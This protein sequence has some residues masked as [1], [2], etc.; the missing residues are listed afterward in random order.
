[1]NEVRKLKREDLIMKRRGLNFIN[2]NVADKLD[3]EQIATLENEVDNVA[4]KIVG[5]L[6]LSAGCDA[7]SLRLEMVKHCIEYQQSLI[8]GGGDP[9]KVIEDDNEFKAYLCPNPGSSTNLGSKKQRLIFLEIDRQ[10]EHTVLEVGKLADI[11]LVVM[12]CKDTEIQGLKVDPD[13]FSHAIDE[14]GYKALGLLRSQGLPS[15]IGVLQHLEQV[16]SKKQPQIKR[17]FQRYFTS[18]FTDRH[19]FMNVNLANAQ[20]DINALL[21]QIAVL[22]PEEITW[23]QNRSYML[24][25]L[26]SHTKNELQFEGYIRNNIINVKRLIHVTGVHPQAFRIKRIEVA[27]DPC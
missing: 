20:T 4:P 22:Y 24:G 25:K 23:K 13:Q 14:T 11:I 21:R 18:E 17:L 10:N 9:E 1:M 26:V 27:K 12:S 16:S 5:I 6:A 8:K 3:E 7:K 15:L 2:E 19:K